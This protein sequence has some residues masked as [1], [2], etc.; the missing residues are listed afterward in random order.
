MQVQID[1][2]FDQL[3][4]I[5]KTLPAGQLKLLKAE[6]ERKRKVKKPKTDFETLLLTGPSRYT[7]TTIKDQK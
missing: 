6:I 4:K 3:L 2:E 1:I 7:K 5:I